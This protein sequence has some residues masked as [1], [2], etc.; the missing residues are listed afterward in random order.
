MTGSSSNCQLQPSAACTFPGIVVVVVV[1]VVLEL[2]WATVGPRPPQRITQA[3]VS[4]VL[5]ALQERAG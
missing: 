1:V 5:W 2:I 4:G 3:S